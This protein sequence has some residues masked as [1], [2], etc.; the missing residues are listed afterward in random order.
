MSDGT[1]ILQI[2]SVQNPRVK[3]VA[4]LLEQRERR[5]SGLLIAEGRRDIG[6][7]LDAGLVLEELYWDEGKL[8]PGAPPEAAAAPHARLCRV[9]DAVLARMGYRQNPADMVAVFRQPHWDLQSVL[10]PPGGTAALFLIAVAVEKPGNLGAMVRTADAA[11]AHAVL[12]ADGV[13][14]PFNPNAI[15][16]STGAVFT[17]PVVAIDG[18]DLRRRLHEMGVQIVAGSP[19]ADR[20]W[21][22]LDM[23]GPTAVAIGAED[24]GLDPFWL[25]DPGVVTASVPMAG[26]SADSLNA[27]VAAAVFLFEALRQ[28]QSGETAESGLYNG[29]G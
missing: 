25:S 28:R 17:L 11:G 12:V 15:R 21:T 7:A 19:H 1:P 16:A 14:D 18:R 23:R 13:C 4:R 3:A 5:R 29:I 10:I 22:Q 9:T 20:A 6:R 24:Q 2:T 27:S 26:R 8:G